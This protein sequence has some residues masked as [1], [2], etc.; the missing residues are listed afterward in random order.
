[1][2]PTSLT[3]A[4]PGLETIER[5]QKQTIGDKI[6]EGSQV[7]ALREYEKFTHEWADF[8]SKVST[9]VGRLESDLVFERGPEFRRKKEEL[10][11]LGKE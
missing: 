5:R 10:E 6:I 7:R 11:M 3:P 9:R 4:E 1:M 2:P 8:K